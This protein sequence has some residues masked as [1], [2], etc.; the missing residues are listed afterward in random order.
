MSAV[1]SPQQKKYLEDTFMTKKDFQGFV[2]TD[3]QGEILG[4]GDKT[5]SLGDEVKDVKVHLRSLESRFESIEEKVDRM[6]KKL[7]AGFGKLDLVLSELIKCREEH[8]IMFFRQEEHT[9]QLEEHEMRFRQIEER[10][11]I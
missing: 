9:R 6:D 4:L 3:F 8:E 7:E 2:K 1:F 11:S 5:Q 10:S